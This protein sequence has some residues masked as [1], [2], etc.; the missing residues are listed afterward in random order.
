MTTSSRACEERTHYSA[1]TNDHMSKSRSKRQRDTYTS[2]SYC[3]PQSR[4]SDQRLEYKARKPG[5]QREPWPLT[6]QSQHHTSAACSW[7]GRHSHWYGDSCL[8]REVY[9][10]LFSC[11]HTA[12]LAHCVSADLR[13]G[14]GIAVEFKKRFSGLEELRRFGECCILLSLVLGFSYSLQFTCV[15]C[16][17]GFSLHCA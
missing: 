6:S 4:V 7:R 2:R 16:D 13:M 10:N 11:P 9:G 1:H 8:I 3:A 17:C 5:S 14:R 15:F 12:S